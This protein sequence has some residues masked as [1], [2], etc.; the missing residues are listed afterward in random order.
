MV[1]PCPTEIRDEESNGSMGQCVSLGYVACVEIASWEINIIQPENIQPRI[2]LTSLYFFS[3][4]LYQ[5]SGFTCL[6]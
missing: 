1:W 3:S 5:A 2:A 4:V 6:A